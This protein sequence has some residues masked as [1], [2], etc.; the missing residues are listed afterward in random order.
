MEL[1]YPRALEEK[2]KPL[3]SR[4]EIIGIRGARQVGKTTL[5]KKLQKEIAG[6]TVFLNMDITENRRAMEEAP[7]D[8][9]RRWKKEP[10]KLC[11]FLDEIQNVKGAGESLKI[12]YDEFPDIK[13]LLSGSSSL[14]LKTKVLPALV[15]RL[16]LFELYTFDFGEFLE[17][18]DPGLHKIYVQKH[19]SLL[20]FLKRKSPPEKPSFS[21]EIIKHWKE[22]VI[23]GGYPEVVKSKDEE[24]KK[25]LLKNIFNLYL[26]KDIA[27]FF[28]IENTSQFEDFLKSLSFIIS[29]LLIVSSLAGKISI[30]YKEAEEFINILQH[31][32]VITL[33]KPFHRNMITEL[34]KAPKMY[35]LDLGLRNAILNNFVPFDNRTDAGQLME[36]YVLRE[37]LS[38][39]Q[40]YEVRFWRTAGKAEVDFILV[41]GN[42]LIPVEVK[43]SEKN[44]GK[45]FYS[46]LE[47][48]KPKQAII[49]TLD[50]FSTQE[51]NGT[52]VYWVPAFYF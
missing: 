13:I 39:F 45:S 47:A 15:G 36:N 42:E 29:N 2:L 46:F 21:E 44:I 9:V 43:L 40:D 17:V 52:M 35:F 10:Q 22:Y 24:E 20:S 27:S 31:T 23:F 30:P 49:V 14:E 50:V 33:L 48:Y 26:E 19:R 28:K 8:L 3:L 16:L 6:D 37:L 38:R 25:L 51:I 12:L 11:L 1:S 41:K 32:Y 7:M 5:L 18:K 4:R 34:K